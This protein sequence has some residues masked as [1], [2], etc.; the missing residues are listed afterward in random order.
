MIKIEK[1]LAEI[2]AS[3]QLPTPIKDSK[4]GKKKEASRP[5]KTTH[6]RRL[7]IIQNKAY[8][9]KPNYNDR[10]KQE[11]TK[12]SLAVIYRK[13]CA[14]C[15]QYI[16]NFHIEHYRPKLKYYWLAFSWDNL[17]LACPT[18]NQH[19]GTHFDIKGMVIDFDDTKDSIRLIH[20][21]S[22]GYDLIEQPKMVNP[23]VTD[24]TGRIQ[25]DKNGSIKSND[26]RFSYTIEKCKIDRIDLNDQRRKLIDIFVADIRSIF[27]E[28]KDPEQRKQGIDVIFRKF[29]RDAQRLDA[30]FLAFRRYAITS[31]WL[32]EII[33]E[34]ERIH[35]NSAGS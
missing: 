34:L 33:K 13:K 17:I 26:E 6:N 25:F 9:D 15:E 22:A 1:N 2:P 11:D 12:A 23:E 5:S 7:E 3:L 24:P 31:G 28:R 20:S 35:T 29:V 4:T 16:E 8:I 18:C 14:F 32:N 21:S 30:P 10:Y 19:K 27:L